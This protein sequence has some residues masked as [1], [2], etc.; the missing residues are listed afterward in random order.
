MKKFISLFLL[1]VSLSPYVSAQLTANAGPDVTVCSG[2]FINLGGNPTATGGTSPYTYQWVSSGS[3]SNAT[4]A[5]PLVIP[6]ITTTYTVTVTDNLG[7]TAVDSVVVT[8]IPLI[9]V[10]INS[11]SISNCGFPDTT[12]FTTTI[13]SGGGLSNY[14]WIFG[15]GTG[16]AQL[17]PTHSYSAPGVYS[18]VLFV[19]DT[20]GCGDTAYAQVNVM[21][22]ITV[23]GQG[24][25]VSCSGASDGFINIT[26]SGANPPF[27]FL[28][29]NGSTTEDLFNL[30]AG[31]YA[32]TVVDGAGCM[33]AASFTVTQ[34]T[35]LN[36]FLTATGES[37]TGACDGLLAATVTGGTPAYMYM[38]S[39]SATTAMQ[40]GLCPG[41]YN[42]TVVDMNNCTVGGSGVVPLA[43]PNNTINVSI[44][45]QDLSCTHPV[46]T[47]KAVV[48]GGT[49]PYTYLWNNFQAS[50]SIIVTQ[51]GI[52]MVVVTDSL[53]CQRSATDTIS[54]LGVTI[55]LEGLSNTTCN[56]IN[57]GSV[58]V[59]VLGG[60]PP[61]T[62]LWSNGTTTDSITGLPAG[63]YTLT[64]TDAASCTESMTW[65]V[66]NG[67][68]NWGYYVYTSALPTNCASNGQATATVY[69]GTAPFTYTWNTTPPQTTA[70]ATNLAPGNY[71]VTITGA[72]GCIRTGN[73]YISTSCHN[74]IT[75]RI[76]NDLNGNCQLDSGETPMYN[77]VVIADG[78]NNY[79]GYTNVQGYYSIKVISGTYNVY[80]YNYNACE[81]VCSGGNSSYNHTFAG[82]GDTVSNNN[83]Y[84]VLP[85]SN[86][87]TTYGSG[88][89]RPGF[90]QVAHVYYGNKG[91]AVTGGTLTFMYDSDLQYVSATGSP[92]HNATTRTLTWTIP[93]ITPG[94]N[95]W[96]NYFNVTFLTPIG[97]PVGT[98]IVNQSYITGAVNDC[99]TADNHYSSTIFVTNSY[100]PNE[101]QVVPTGD[102]QEEDSVLTYTI[103]FQNTGNDTAWFVILKD[104]LSQHLEPATVQNIA[105]SHTITEFTVSG[106]GILSW[107]FNPIYLVD[108]A[109]N[110]AASKGFVTFKVKKKT[111]LPLNTQIQNT[112]HIYF[113]YNDA[114]VTNT[115]SSKLT[116][117]DN[118]W[119]LTNDGNIEVTAAP[120]P[121]TQSTLITVDGVTSE[122][123]FELYDV[124]G[125]LI[126]NIPTVN[127]SRFVIQREEMS[128]GVYFYSITTA[129]KQK[130][131]GRLVV[132]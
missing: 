125:K 113:D 22:S 59:E 79:Y 9:Q 105:A 5:N 2:T 98:A 121:F 61:F 8:V 129:N 123:S 103:H 70:T 118:V 27:T 111:D 76:I 39:N 14:Q 91:A 116:N 65:Y 6:Y 77:R 56:G 84:L 32:V 35:P 47:L 106:Q 17:N 71:M 26:A 68:T 128:Q 88:N 57:N 53:G 12:N 45:S 15:D 49:P 54:D 86:L 80:L 13:I 108:S 48:S 46:D 95:S 30:S 73:T 33:A 24:N 66:N 101:K 7:Q 52:Y 81:T 60:T 75:G 124:S 11:T 43:C 69:G 31:T 34:P 50:Q 109:T 44:T 102:I 90:N 4:M 114:I 10:Q 122:F 126:K 62:Y 107:V 58:S 55:L 100:D 104:T 67:G 82:L 127:E 63:V 72:D 94:G 112:A 83:F 19:Y 25:S 78:V 99:D 41:T 18:V 16:S 85:A 21:P 74:V 29:N 93:S 110:E 38:W 117:P 23:N 1:L 64:V 37:A 131:F 51:G 40:T 42:I 3:M 120:N 130:A 97:T 119:S 132:Q 115:V 20:L 36:L 87:Y 89:F 92:A 96:S 28:W